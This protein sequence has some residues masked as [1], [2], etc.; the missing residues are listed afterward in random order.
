MRV[1][2]TGA[3][4][5]IGR[6]VMARLRQTPH[7]CTCLVRPGSRQDE[8]R[9]AG[10]RI[11]EG[12]ILDSDALLAGMQGQDSVVHLAALYSF[13]ERDPRRYD[14]VNVLGTR[15]VM[16][17]ALQAGVSKVILVSTSLVYGVPAERPFREDAPAGRGLL[18]KYARSKWAGER[19]AWE[20]HHTRGL[21][22][23]VLYPGGVL[24]VGDVKAS[25]WSANCRRACLRTASSPG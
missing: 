24:G 18:S 10:A 22:L 12:D 5:F 11:V 20:L 9:A 6:H 4:G 16:E 19:F 2:I 25:G 3:T 13:W 8:L 7:A 23:V 1:F 14:A 15:C 21:P 17:S